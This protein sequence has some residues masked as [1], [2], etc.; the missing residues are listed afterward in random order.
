[1]WKQNSQLTLDIKYDAHG[2]IAS[3]MPWSHNTMWSRFISSITNPSFLHRSERVSAHHDKI[4]W[5]N[6]PKR[7]TKTNTI[8]VSLWKLLYMEKKNQTSN[9]SPLHILRPPKESHGTIPVKYI[10]SGISL[11]W[12]Q[13]NWQL[14]RLASP[15]SYQVTTWAK[16]LF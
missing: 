11:R 14:P 12:T 8:L 6:S 1:M 10:Y 9:M 15:N 5:K 3:H 2:L 13:Q 4:K 16:T 7:K